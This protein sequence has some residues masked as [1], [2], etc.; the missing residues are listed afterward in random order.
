[1][2]EPTADEA[3]FERAR[4]RL[5]AIAYGL[6]GDAGEAEDAVQDAWL[7]WQAAQTATVRE[8]EA[9]LVT[10]VTRLAL[11]RLKSAR[12]RRETYVGPW[13]PEPWALRPLDDPADVVAQAESLSL[14]LLAA[15]ERLNPVERAVLLL[16]DVFDLDYAE[17]AEAV[18]RTPAT[19]RQVAK[20]ARERAGDPQPRFTPLPE[21]ESRLAEAFAAASDAGSVAELTELLAAD[22]VAW[23]DGGGVVKAARKPIHGAERI[24]RFL[25]NLRLRLAPPG[26]TIAAVRINGDAGIRVDFPGGLLSVTA[27]EIADGRVVGLRSVSNPAKLTRVAATPSRPSPPAAHGRP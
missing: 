18:Q 11:D 13:L 24:A 9:F 3:V 25:S 17:V 19:C 8:P 5:E 15:L 10:V 22:A 26:T 23:S 27:L 20:R 6:L 14:A 4:A 16:R 1:M 12:V 21:A 7:R 2:S